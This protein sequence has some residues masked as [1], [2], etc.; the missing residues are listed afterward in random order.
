MSY[1]LFKMTYFD[2]WSDISQTYELYIWFILVDHLKQHDNT[3]ETPF[4]SFFLNNICI[5]QFLMNFSNMSSHCMLMYTL[6]CAKLTIIQ[7][8]LSWV[9]YFHVSF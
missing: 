6:K 1:N 3:T 2:K 9:K 8:L 5:L 7:S 4:I